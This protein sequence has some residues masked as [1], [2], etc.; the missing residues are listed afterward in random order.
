MAQCSRHYS[1]L[2]LN[3]AA[4]AVRYTGLLVLM[5][6][7]YAQDAT[8]CDTVKD[9]AQQMVTRANELKAENAELLKRINELEKA[10]TA[11]AQEVNKE[12]D[13][14]FEAIRSGSIVYPTVGGN[15]QSASCPD[16]T[17]MVAARFQVGPGG[18]AG[19]VSNILPV[20]RNLGAP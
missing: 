11:Q 18:T 12:L 4:R 19:I 2:T 1:E 15:A 5:S 13:K 8:T 3:W 14:R 16:G 6:P 9:C 17:F 7:A 10:L 20:C